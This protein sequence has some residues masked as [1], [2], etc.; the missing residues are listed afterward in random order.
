MRWHEVTGEALPGP[1]VR[2]TSPAGTS[3]VQVVRTVPERIYEAVPDGDFGI[4]ESYSGLSESATSFVYLENQFLW[5]PEIA[6]VLARRS[7]NAH[8]RPDFR[9]LLVFPASP[10]RAATTRVG[11][12]PS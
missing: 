1:A 9:V 11:R 12:S 4:L 6:R 3:N 7:S 5:S 10:P 8:R 2:D